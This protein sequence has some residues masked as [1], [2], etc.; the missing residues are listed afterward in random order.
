M[1]KDSDIELKLNWRRT[2]PDRN[3]DFAC[4]APEHR[5]NVGRIC[6]HAHGPTSGPWFWSYQ[7][8]IPG[9]TRGADSTGMAPSLR[10]AAKAIE[11][12]WFADFEKAS[13]SV[14]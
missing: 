14:I 12:R 5:G 13:K 3:H 7:G 1:G 2:W 6:L 8:H 11:D 9:V 10:E 4:A